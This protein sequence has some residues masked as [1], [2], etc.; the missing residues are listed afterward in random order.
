MSR[1]GGGLKPDVFYCFQIDGPITEE[2]DKGL[3]V[4][5]FAGVI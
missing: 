3:Q 2:G 1:G 4:F 5:F